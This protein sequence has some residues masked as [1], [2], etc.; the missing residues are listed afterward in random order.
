MLFQWIRTSIAMKP[1]IFFYFLGDLDPLSPKHPLWIHPCNVATS[2]EL[3]Y[4]LVHI[5]I[6]SIC[7]SVACGF[8]ILYTV[9]SEIFARIFVFAKS[10]KRH[11][12]DVNN[13]RLRKDLPISIS[14]IVILPF[15]EGFIFT[16]LR[17]REVSRK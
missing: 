13:A 10:I 12:S 5:I 14:D 16:K 7:Y 15:C 17:I 1:Y 9:D 2:S 11:I 6:K 4:P 8:F 3:Y